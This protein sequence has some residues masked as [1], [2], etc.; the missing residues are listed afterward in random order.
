MPCVLPGV[1]PLKTRE[2]GCA[3]RLH[4]KSLLMIVVALAN[5][6]FGCQALA[7]SVM[8]AIYYLL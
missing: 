4:Y 6:A 2:H 7:I 5:I 1:R 8:S 3:A